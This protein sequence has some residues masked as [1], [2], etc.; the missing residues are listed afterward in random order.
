MGKDT[1]ISE[2]VCNN[3]IYKYDISV[4]VP[5]FNSEQY[6]TSCIDSILEQNFEN[7]QIVLVDDGSSDGSGEICD[8]YAQ[9]H[10]N[11]KAIHQ[12]N[13]G[14]AFTRNIGTE[15]ADGEYVTYVDS[16]DIIDKN[17]LRT[18]FDNIKINN[19]D[20]SLCEIRPFEN[21]IVEEK[22]SAT[23]NIKVFSGEEALGYTLY[24][25]IRGTSACAILFTTLFARENKFA[26]GKYHEDDLITI[27][28]YSNA[29][30]VVYS[31]QPLYYYRQHNGSIMHTFN[32]QILSDL[33]DAGDY[34]EKSCR[35]YNIF[36]QNA[37][38]FKKFDDY[39]IAFF[40]FPEL[41]EAN[42]YLYDR[43]LNGIKD[44]SKHILKDKNA[45][46]K[47]RLY[48]LLLIIGGEK[49]ILFA[50]KIMK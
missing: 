9:K 20:I 49:V 40:S 47:R 18:L 44:L 16:D 26:V 25:K 34:I 37:S 13:H 50:H 43:A 27:K 31:A 14:P 4:V 30:S 39:W 22:T 42:R 3:V 38:K 36:V 15:C 48:C 23:Q 17:Y 7:F 29:K 5:V 32:P 33:M 21:E 1:I 41:K 28:Y 6:L 2:M 19:A 10:D 46:K 35:K 24:G 11:I 45:G 12:S 8:E